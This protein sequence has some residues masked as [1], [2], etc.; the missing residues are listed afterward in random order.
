MQ[1]GDIYH[2]EFS[3]F[4]NPYF[5]NTRTYTTHRTPICWIKTQLYLAKLITCIPPGTLRKIPNLRQCIPCK[6]EWSHQ[7]IIYEILYISNNLNSYGGLSGFA[8]LNLSY[9]TYNTIT[10][11]LTGAVTEP[12]DSGI[13]FTASSSH[14]LSNCDQSA[15]SGSSVWLTGNSRTSWRQVM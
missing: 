2:A 4:M 3:T 10:S 7:L 11:T 13:P 1:L 8:T 12:K 14:S 5:S 9:W 15:S 6:L